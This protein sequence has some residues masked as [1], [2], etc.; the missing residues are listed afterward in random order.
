MIKL[1]AGAKGQGKTKLLLDTANSIIHKDDESVIV[2]IDHRMRSTYSLHHKIRLVET[3]EYPLS[4]YREFIG[5]I[6]GILSQNHDIGYIFVDSLSNILKDLSNDDL[7]KLID[8]IEKLS[9]ENGFVIYLGV[10][11]TPE[12][13]P[14]E[15]KKLLV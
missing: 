15:A 13:L 1:V 11:C 12:D 4:N 5:F 6:C 2:F 10:T 7:V 9:T 3:Y 14:G 8:K